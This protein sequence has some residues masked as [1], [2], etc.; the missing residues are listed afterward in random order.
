MLTLAPKR[1]LTAF[2]ARPS[3]HLRPLRAAR[4]ALV[5]LATSVMTNYARKRPTIV[6]A[7]NNGC[8][9]RSDRPRCSG[10]DLCRL[11]DD[12]PTP[13]RR[14]PQSCHCLTDR[15]APSWSTRAHTTLH[16]GSLAVRLERQRSTCRRHASLASS[17]DS[18]LVS[19]FAG[20]QRPLLPRRC[21]HTP[22]A[23][24]HWPAC[25]S[26]LS[27]RRISRRLGPPPPDERRGPR[28]RGRLTREPLALPR[29]TPRSG[30][31]TASGCSGSP[32]Q[33][34]GRKSST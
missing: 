6:L 5:T 10:S 16:V 31:K 27:S 11:H 12:R 17:I 7:A 8:V 14:V 28:V 13:H 23:L 2:G 1:P 32:R 25:S 15:I 20:G 24:P 18:K 29:A 33:L 30:G 26:V 21:E 9:L 4:A 34:P 19:G 3:P 22:A